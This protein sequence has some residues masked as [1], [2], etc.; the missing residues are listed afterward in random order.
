MAS[1]PSGV[2]GLPEVG[3]L[4]RQHRIDAGLTQEALAER[5][6]LGVRSIQGIELGEHR[7]RQDTVRRLC[8]ALG[9]AGPDWT[10]VEAATRPAPRARPAR[11][12][13]ARL[14]GLPI[15][16]GAGRARG[17][18]LPASLTSFVGRER[19]LATIQD[20]LG[21][22]RL[23]TLTGA[24]G[25][26]KTRLAL[27]AAR[28]LLDRYPDGVWLVDLAPLAD[29]SLIP[30]TV[31]T[32][33]DLRERPVEPVVATL[34]TFLEN[35]Q[36]LLLL[37]NCEHLI[38]ACANLVAALLRSCG[39]VR[40]LATSREPL[41]IAGEA[42]WRVPSLS[43]VDPR[44]ITQGNT[45]TVAA[46]REAESVQL[47]VDRARLGAPGFELTRDNAVAVAQICQHLDGIPLAIELA[48]ARVRALPVALLSRRLDDRFRLLREGNRAALPRQRTLRATI[49]W[50]YD[51]LAE[52]EQILFRRLAV[53]AR[54]WDLEAAES[55]CG[56]EEAGTAVDVV[57]LLTRL[58]D[59][60]LVVLDESVGH[61]RY[62]YLETIQQYAAER[63]DEAGEAPRFRRRHCRFYLNLAERA[64]LELYRADQRAW[65]DRL[66]LEQDNL[67][68]AL[69]ECLAT[70]P[71]AGLRLAGAL[72]RFWLDRGDLGEARSLLEKLLA[73]A[74][75][76]EPSRGRALLTF[77]IV[78]T[79]HGDQATSQSSIERGLAILRSNGEE[80]HIAHALVWLGRVVGLGGSYAR[81]REYLYEGL[82]LARS[83]GE[84]TNVI[85]ALAYLGELDEQEGLLETAKALYLESLDVSRNAGN[86]RGWDFALL[87][88]GAVARMQGDLTRAH[89]YLGEC[90]ALAWRIG[91]GWG[92]R[93]LLNEYA[94]LAEVEGHHRRS[95]R[96]LGAMAR[97]QEAAGVLAGWVGAT[98][99]A[100]RDRVRERLGENAFAAA[101]A[102]GQA[103][104][105]EQTVA[106]ALGGRNTA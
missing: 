29:P 25:V 51:L 2:A 94:W 33:L 45:D 70:D 81:A 100:M 44:L 47:F 91:H 101:W 22:A 60:S 102:E 78:V 72:Q 53:F 18:N 74:P 56:G 50:S 49:D 87:R 80:W 15:E 42:T 4:L 19:D 63:L 35:R 41:G 20:L 16:M 97:A 3:L 86:L 75:E 39:L 43:L 95:A 76:Q 82:T 64:E 83:S 59:K 96:L 98:D 38:Q 88:L 23:L 1:E 90:L 21:K 68:A 54:G 31:A 37:D 24:G 85:F 93:N 66:H 7:P 40:I 48:A 34:L 79:A 46:V 36:V 6:G 58:V 5:T 65:M 92:I 11:G 9:L 14:R 13:P 73:R 105:L 27:Q 28:S 84:P 10:R 32:A 67:R 77:G 57:D 61:A 8:Q 106:Y 104:T 12:A 30:L 52:P 55:V 17:H 62:H 26:G 103:M 99:G 69:R 71:A 89:K